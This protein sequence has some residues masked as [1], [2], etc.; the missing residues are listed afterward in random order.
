MTSSMAQTDA[1]LLTKANKKAIYCIY[2]TAEL[3]TA[4]NGCTIMAFMWE[5]SL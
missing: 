5:R 1:E 4:H 2:Y 3:T